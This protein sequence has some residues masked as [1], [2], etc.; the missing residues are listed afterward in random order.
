M[1]SWHSACMYGDRD[2]C[3]GHQGIY[4]SS[5]LIT[6]TCESQEG[7]WYYIYH[8]GKKKTCMKIVWILCK[9]KKNAVFNF[10]ENHIFDIPWLQKDPK[11]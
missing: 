8:R 6:E 2:V 7:R 11:L 4:K 10:W 5:L 3:S 1:P 9:I